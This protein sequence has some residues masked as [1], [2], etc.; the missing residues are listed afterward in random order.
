[1]HLTNYSINKKNVVFDKETDDGQGYKWSHTALKKLMSSAGIDVKMIWRQIE[2]IV[3]KTIISGE[4][5]MRQ[6]QDQYVPFSNC[7][8]LFGFDILIDDTLNCWLI[9][10]N[11]SPSLGCESQPGY[12]KHRGA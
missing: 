9:E 7:F 3:I 4:F 1:M 5:H 12:S 6:A 8:E 11:L 2:D 10:V